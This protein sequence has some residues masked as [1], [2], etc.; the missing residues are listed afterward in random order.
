MSEK[1][2]IEDKLSEDSHWSSEINK[3]ISEDNLHHTTLNS[4]HNKADM[5]AHHS[6]HP[7]HKKKWTEYLLEF[8][9]LFLAVFLGFVAENIRE[10]V[11]E[12]HREKEFMSSMARDLELDTIQFSRIRKYN[13][14]KLK[15]TDSV[16]AFFW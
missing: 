3:N 8:F 4:P 13:A 2:N 15:L 11:V 14:N 1:Q 7:T 12:R 6:H 16:I 5:E 10:N 9:M